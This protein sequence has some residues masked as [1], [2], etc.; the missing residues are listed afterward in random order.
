MKDI[1]N[2]S[3]CLKEHMKKVDIDTNRIRSILKVCSIREKVI[4]QIIKDEDTV[5]I[6]VESYYEII[7]E[8]FT[9]LLLS[10]GRKSDNHECLIS[11]FKKEYTEYEFES[12][13]IHTLKNAR[14]KINYEGLIIRKEYLEQNEFEFDSIIGILKKEIEAKI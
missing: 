8:L 2:F 6:I 9:A 12:F 10:N 11:F 4:K 3:E 13:I 14:N 1:M 7:K 5:T